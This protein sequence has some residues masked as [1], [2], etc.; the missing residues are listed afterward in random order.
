VIDEFGA[1]AGL[2][3]LEDLVEEIV[4]EIQD[5]YDEEELEVVSLPDG[6]RTVQARM[7]LDDFNEFFDVEIPEGDYDTIGGFL[8]S[9]LGRLPNL[10]EELTYES[11]NFKATDVEGHRLMKVLVR[12]MEKEDGVE[13]ES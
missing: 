12:Q 6:S 3:T 9:L 2:V 8:I 13:E 1:V 7:D 4:G 11:L 5:E 10:G